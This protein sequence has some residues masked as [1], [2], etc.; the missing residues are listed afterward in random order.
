MRLAD[1]QW[2]MTIAMK[3]SAVLMKLGMSG[4]IKSIPPY[5]GEEK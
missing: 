5:E 1:P 2:L 3:M 4:C